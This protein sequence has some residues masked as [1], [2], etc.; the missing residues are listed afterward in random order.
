MQGKIAQL[1]FSGGGIFEIPQHGRCLNLQP[2]TLAVDH[3][4]PIVDGVEPSPV[5][6]LVGGVDHQQEQVSAA[7]INYQVVNRFA[8]GIQQK[9]ITGLA[10]AQPVGIVGDDG[11]Q[12]SDGV[13]PRQLKA[14]HV[15]HVEQAG[16]LAHGSVLLAHAAIPNGHLPTGK[17]HDIAAQRFVRLEKCGPFERHVFQLGP[18]P[19]LFF[20]GGGCAVQAILTHKVRQR[21]VKALRVALEKGLPGCPRLGHRWRDLVDFLKLLH[22]A[23]DHGALHLA[24]DILVVEQDVTIGQAPQP[25]LNPFGRLSAD[26]HQVAVTAVL[27][28]FQPYGGHVIEQ[29]ALAVQK[30]GARGLA[31]FQTGQVTRT[32]LLHK[33]TRPPTA[34]LQ[35]SGGSRV[36]PFL[37]RFNKKVRIVALG[38]CVI[39][40]SFVGQLGHFALDALQNIQVDLAARQFPGQPLVCKGMDMRDDV[41]HKAGDGIHILRA[42]STLGDPRGAKADSAGQ[43]GQVIARNRVLVHD[44]AGQVK[45]A[46][47]HLA[48]QGESGGCRRR[49]YGAYIQHHDVGVRATVSHPQSPSLEGIGKRA[50]ILNGAPLQT[51]ELLRLRQFKGHAQR[52]ELVDVR[53]TLRPR[54]DGH[55]DHIGFVF[56]GGQDDGATRSAQRLVGSEHRHVS[57]AHRVRV[58][59]ADDQTRGVGD[60]GHEQG[61]HRIGDLAELGPV[62]CPSVG[63]VTGDDDAGL[64]LQRQCHNLFII[65]AFGAVVHAV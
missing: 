5:F 42:K 59:A 36:F 37:G 43:G 26:S 54:K 53:A 17:G 56:V 8:I 49:L 35:I 3:D 57:D 29:R 30:E 28:R 10:V 11:I 20:C 51:C 9:S 44:D 27:V 12:E 18:G 48:A 41:V 34:D 60:V 50:R 61:P 55:I 14:A 46:R 23:N 32:D 2:G 65:Q 58:D 63:R 4:A 13:R 52:G 38:G 62:R 31:R 39:Y 7:P 45:Y 6:V 33:R 25:G 16:G 1:S 40:P 21:Q 22:L 64:V 15:A 24:K 19:L 47:R